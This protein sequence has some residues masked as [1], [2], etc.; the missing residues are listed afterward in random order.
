M[1]KSILTILSTLIFAGS[2][3]AI[4]SSTLEI[5]ALDESGISY[6]DVAAV[7]ADWA[8]GDADLQTYIMNHFSAEAVE[9]VLEAVPKLETNKRALISITLGL[10]MMVQQKDDFDVQKALINIS[11][12]NELLTK[13]SLS[14]KDVAAA[15]TSQTI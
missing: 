1:K 11:T 9:I 7:S 14:I 12:H 5:Q 15:I 3:F 13:A 8:A 10:V 6:A 2:A 4:E